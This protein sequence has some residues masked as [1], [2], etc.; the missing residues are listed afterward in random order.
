MW[1]FYYLIKKQ[2]KLHERCLLQTSLRRN[3][4]MA[5]SFSQSTKL[6]VRAGKCSFLQWM[7]HSLSLRNQWKSFV[8]LYSSLLLQEQSG[9]SLLHWHGKHWFGFAVSSDPFPPF[10]I[11]I[12]WKFNQNR[13]QNT[14][15]ETVQSEQ[16]ITD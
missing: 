10:S 16:C 3:C 7:L 15:F 14:Q 13:K 6:S 2:I 8:N 4:Y 12:H 5:S 11:L 9:F 1:V